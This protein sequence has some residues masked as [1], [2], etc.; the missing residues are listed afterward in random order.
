MMRKLL[1]ALL[2][3]ALIV[4]VTVIS[5]PS[6]AAP[7]KKKAPPA[8]PAIEMQKLIAELRSGNETRQIKAAQS[9]TKRGKPGAAAA[10]ALCEVI[11]GGKG[12]APAEAIVA[13][14]SITPDLGKATMTIL[15]EEKQPELFN[16]ACQQISKWGAAA[17]PAAPVLVSCLHKRTN[18][19]P[20]FLPSAADIESAELLCRALGDA[21]PGSPQAVKLL[22]TLLATKNAN[23]R[24]QAAEALG[25]IGETHPALRKKL[26]PLL[27]ESLAEATLRSSAAEALQRFGPDARSAL[28]ALKGHL[29][30]PDQ[31]IREVV[32]QAMAKIGSGK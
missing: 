13:L 32:A 2:L 17:Q 16:Q 21:R 11:V 10:E 23:C 24:N 19:A 6:S 4:G 28:P 26:L 3:G 15:V 9:L 25:K 18:V 7:K 20:P 14:Q 29:L 31:K 5:G 22:S 8:V 1:V 27:I 30:D 12:E